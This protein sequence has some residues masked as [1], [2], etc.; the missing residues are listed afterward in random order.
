[1][2][3][4]VSH[5]ILIFPHG[6][7]FVANPAISRRIDGSAHSIILRKWVSKYENQSSGNFDKSEA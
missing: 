6:Q 3:N 2:G 4:S 1:M 5:A 7:K